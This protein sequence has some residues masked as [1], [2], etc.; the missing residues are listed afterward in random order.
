M[1]F[2]VLASLFLPALPRSLGAAERIVTRQEIFYI[3]FSVQPTDPQQPAPTE[4][5]LFVSGDRGGHW[6][7]YQTQPP[8][9][10]RFSFRVGADGEFWFAVR[11]RTTEVAAAATKPSVPELMVVVD[12]QPPNVKLDVNHDANDQVTAGWQI[13][14]PELDMEADLGIDSIKRVEILNNFRKVMP[15]D[16]K[17]VL[18]VMEEATASGLSEDE[19][20]IRVMAAAHG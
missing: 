9:A 15:Q 2:L 11:T 6:E 19:T 1:A 8:E 4:V 18:A 20:M 5:D 10:G 3:P 12:R 13:V 7:T 17:R 14:D 16:F